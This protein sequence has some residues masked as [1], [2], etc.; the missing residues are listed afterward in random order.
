MIVNAGLNL[1]RDFFN[2]DSPT[3]P[4]H[5]AIGTG[6][7]AVNAADT[8]LGSEVL[9]KTISKE[10]KSNAGVIEYFVNISSTEANGNNLSEIGIFNAS[11]GGTMI[12]RKTHLAYQKTSSFGV[13][14]VIRHTIQST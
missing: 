1:I 13:K 4:S 5:L 12:L 3:P 10:E 6:T 7:T 14:I 8:E 11:S 2:G 9:R